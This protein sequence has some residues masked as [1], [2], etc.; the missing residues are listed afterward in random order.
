[1]RFYLYRILVAILMLGV[2][3]GVC[4]YFFML[5]EIRMGLYYE[6]TDVDKAVKIYDT[7]VMSLCGDSDLANSF[8]RLFPRTEF[9]IY[10][11]NLDDTQLRIVI[12]PKSLLNFYSI[13]YSFFLTE[14]YP[15]YLEDVKNTIFK[16]NLDNLMDTLFPLSEYLSS[17]P[18]EKYLDYQPRIRFAARRLVSVALSRYYC[19]THILPCEDFKVCLDLYLFVKH[20]WFYLKFLF[21]KRLYIYS[22]MAEDITNW[23]S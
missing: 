18:P 1:M 19:Y 5:Y 7:V 11:K 2:Y 23:I 17:T 14:H 20:S 13:S 6:I 16:N 8:F 21:L 9:Y 15:Y 4:G 22:S 12:I 10:A 3:S